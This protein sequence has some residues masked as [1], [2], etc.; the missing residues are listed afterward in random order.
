MGFNLC[1]ESPPHPSRH[2]Q[3]RFPS[4]KVFANTPQCSR[5]S[6]SDRKSSFIQR[7][8][9]NNFYPCSEECDEFGEPG[10]RK[11]WETRRIVRQAAHGA[12]HGCTAEIK[13][14]RTD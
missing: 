12:E 2:L 5:R 11:W 6:L 9:V 3:N 7:Q 4:E 14:C 1:F 8:K 10:T 13:T